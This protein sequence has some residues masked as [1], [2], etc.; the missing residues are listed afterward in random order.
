MRAPF[1]RD[2]S[3]GAGRRAAGVS[4]AMLTALRETAATCCSS[5]A[6]WSNEQEKVQ[7]Q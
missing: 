7:L 5:G 4:A 1:M 3:C 6:S 2:N